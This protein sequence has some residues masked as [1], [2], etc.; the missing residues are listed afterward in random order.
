MFFS[1]N[2]LI[3]STFCH[4]VGK[5]LVNR[6]AVASGYAAD[7]GTVVCFDHA[8]VIACRNS[9][10][11]ITNETADVLAVCVCHAQYIVTV[12]IFGIGT[13][14]NRAVVVNGVDIVS[15]IHS[16][17]AITAQV[18]VC[19]LCATAFDTSFIDTNQAADITNAGYLSVQTVDKRGIPNGSTIRTNQTTRAIRRG[20]IIAMNIAMIGHRDL[21]QISFVSTYDAACAAFRGNDCTFIGNSCVYVFINRRI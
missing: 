11:V 20:C 21:C 12:G 19:I 13:D 6:T 3:V 2:R 18:M 4:N 17:T 5:Y 8:R 10:L 16:T 7:V 1:M 14:L 9:T 15:C